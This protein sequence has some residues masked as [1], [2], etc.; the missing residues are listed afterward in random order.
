MEETRYRVVTSSNP[1]AVIN[2]PICSLAKNISS[3]NGSCSGS[4][5]VT[6]PQHHRVLG[7]LRPRQGHDDRHGVRSRRNPLR[8][9]RGEGR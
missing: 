5:D 8:R 9:H 7:Q 1:G 4:F 6:P 3:G 2:V